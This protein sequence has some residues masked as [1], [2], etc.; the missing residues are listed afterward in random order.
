MN[1]RGAKFQVNG[2]QNNGYFANNAKYKCFYVQMVNKWDSLAGLL[3]DKAETAPDLPF[4][5]L[6]FS[7]QLETLSTEHLRTL[8]WLETFFFL[9]KSFLFLK[10]IFAFCK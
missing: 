9:N 3:G 7:W 10:T 8:S 5:A 6:A 1:L 2:A 4:P